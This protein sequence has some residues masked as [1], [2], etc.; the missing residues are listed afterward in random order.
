MTIRGA[1]GGED[2]MLSLA[3]L[4]DVND[5]GGA[6]RKEGIQ[7]DN[8]RGQPAFQG[9]IQCMKICTPMPCGTGAQEHT[10]ES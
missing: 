7:P 10:A 2:L 8:C 9:K 4:A 5:A 6:T 3:D 1:A